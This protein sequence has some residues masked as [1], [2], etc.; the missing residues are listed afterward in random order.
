MQESAKTKPPLTYFEV[1]EGFSKTDPDSNEMLVSLGLRD[2]KCA[3]DVC[4]SAYTVSIFYPCPTPLGH[5]KTQT[6]TNYA[7]TFNSPKY[8]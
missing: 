1:P 3:P 4:E 5:L 8:P 2:T 7:S 6:I